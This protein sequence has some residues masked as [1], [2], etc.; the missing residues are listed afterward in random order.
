VFPDRPELPPAVT[1]VNRFPG[2]AAK[3]RALMMEI[4][5]APGNSP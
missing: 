2:L 5:D 3:T 1:D 4:L